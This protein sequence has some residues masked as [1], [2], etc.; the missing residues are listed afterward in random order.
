MATSPKLQQTERVFA[1][2]RKKRLMADPDFASGYAAGGAM[3]PVEWKR[4]FPSPHRGFRT[5]K[6]TAVKPLG[7]PV[8][9]P[10]TICPRCYDLPHRRPKRG[11]CKCG[12]VFG[13]LPPD[14]IPEHDY[15]KVI[16]R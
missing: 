5:V 2:A 11:A 8:R 16:P 10:V 9:D 15:S 12:E 4:G 14:P 3:K 6:E 13:T 1:L 7:R